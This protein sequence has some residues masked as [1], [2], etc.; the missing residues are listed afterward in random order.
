MDRDEEFLF[1]YFSFISQMCF[2]K[3]KEHIEKEKEQKKS[4]NQWSALLIQLQQ[5]NLAEKSYVELGF[6]QNKSKGFLR[7]DNSLRSIYESIKCDMKKI[8][9]SFDRYQA[10]EISAF[11]IS[12]SQYISCRINLIDL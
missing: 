7:K 10:N 12:T 1:N 3:A 2:D 5:L 9:E 11:C 4:S 6:L 8:E